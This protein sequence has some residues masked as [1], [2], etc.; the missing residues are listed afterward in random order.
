MKRGI[1]LLLIALGLLIAPVPPEGVETALIILL[2]PIIGF[3]NAF[4]FVTLLASFLILT[5]LLLLGRKRRR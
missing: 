2:T 5:G 3:L 4:F 1:G